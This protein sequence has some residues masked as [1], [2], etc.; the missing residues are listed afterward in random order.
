MSER[1]EVP[2]DRYWEPGWE[3]AND[4]PLPED[5]WICDEELPF[6]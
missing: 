5:Q 4:E 6:E 2:G 3:D 1:Y